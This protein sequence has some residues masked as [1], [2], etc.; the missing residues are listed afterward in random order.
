[1]HEP[2]FS[3]L[4]Y[5]ALL[6]LFLEWVPMTLFILLLL[7]ISIFQVI[8]QPSAS[9]YSLCN[10][11]APTF[12]CPFDYFYLLVH[13]WYAGKWIHFASHWQP[14]LS[15]ESLHIAWVL[16]QERH[17]F[18]HHYL[19]ILSDSDRASRTHYQKCSSK[20]LSGN[21][22][23]CFYH[24]LLTHYLVSLALWLGMATSL[25]DNSC[26]FACRSSI[27]H[28]FMLCVS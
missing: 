19:L 5:C 12:F 11:T 25:D 15:W 7:S 6:L 17:S 4:K 26:K 3:F 24:S 9:K 8:F 13:W 10:E 16:R 28:P 23:E 2:F 1:M 21:L 27:G 14:Y 18:W 22:E 20:A